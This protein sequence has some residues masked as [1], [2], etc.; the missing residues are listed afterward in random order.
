MAQYLLDTNILWDVVRNP[1]GVVIKKM[2]RM[3]REERRS[4][5]TSIV[6]AGELRFGGAKKGSPHLIRRIEEV[7][8]SVKVL[9]LE[10]D[11]DRHYARLRLQRERQGSPISGND[12]LIAAHAL[13]TN[14]ILVTANTREF[15]RIPDLS[16]QNWLRP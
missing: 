11:A 14:S 13:A 3:S 10:E 5:C 12:L 7:L 8:E 4:L 9:P 6:V 16:V 15:A 1:T 2:S